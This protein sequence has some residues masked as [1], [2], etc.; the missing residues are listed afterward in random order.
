MNIRRRH[1]KQGRC[2]HILLASLQVFCIGQKLESKIYSK[3]R[4][5]LILTILTFSYLIK[6]Q[7]NY[8]I[9]Q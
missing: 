5:S 3:D 1:K 6:N 2:G 4:H 8:E 9:F 7:Q